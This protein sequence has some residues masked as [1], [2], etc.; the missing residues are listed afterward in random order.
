MKLT[1]EDLSAIKDLM[2]VTIEEKGVT[3]EEFEERLKHLPTKDEFYTET[4]RIY[5]QL[6]GAE[7]EKDVLTYR[8]SRHSDQIS[9]IEKHLAL[10]E[11]D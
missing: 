2:E 5:K 6:E 1:S 9:R 7:E 3:K 10:P 11:L 4:A 8:V